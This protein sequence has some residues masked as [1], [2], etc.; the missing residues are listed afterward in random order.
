MK[1]A[2]KSEEHLSGSAQKEAPKERKGGHRKVTS[3]AWRINWIRVWDTLGAYFLMD[4]LAALVFAG[5]FIYGMDEQFGGGFSFDY[6]RKIVSETILPEAVYQVSDRQGTLLYQWEIGQWLWLLRL[7]ACLVI[8]CQIINVIS[9]LVHGAEQ[10]RRQLK[11]LDEIAAKAKELQALVADENKYHNLED[12]IANLKGDVIESGIHMNDRELR[13]IEQ[14]LNDLLARIRKTY[15]QQDQFVSDASHEL[16]TP[17]AVIQGY[18][19]M[20]DRWGKEDEKILAESIEAIQHEADHMQKLVEQLLF[21]ARGDSNRQS[22]DMGERQLADILAEIYEESRMIDESH[23]YLFEHR[24]D[25]VVWGDYDM[26]KQSVRILVDNAAKYTADGGEIILRVG[27]TKEGYPYYEIQDGGIGM[28]QQ[29]AERV[30]DRFYR[31]DAVRSSSGGTG[32]GLSIAKWITDKHKG[33]YDILSVEGLGTRFHVTFPLPDQ[34]G[35]ERE[36]SHTTQY[37]NEAKNLLQ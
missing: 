32:L 11:P 28:S 37:C 29:D 14:A 22:L 8:F 1:R 35:G 36:P 21:L 33:R 26:L 2:K 24:Q 5:V 34:S 13:G 30:F 10:V 23:V 18:V 7:G 12:A 17:I 4:I 9:L 25:A 27:C 19:N 3:I 15:R 6:T 31:A 16:R 20:L